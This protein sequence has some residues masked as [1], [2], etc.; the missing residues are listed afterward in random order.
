MTTGVLRLSPSG[1]PIENSDGGGLIP[2]EGIVMRAA[3]ENAAITSGFSISGTAAFELK[4]NM[5]DANAPFMRPQLT[6]ARLNV[7]YAAELNY[8]MAVADGWNTNVVTTVIQ[9]SIDDGANWITLATNS[10]N[11][12]GISANA[13]QNEVNMHIRTDPF[14]G[15]TVTGLTEGGSL[16]LR[17]TVMSGGADGQI[18]FRGTGDAPS[19]YLELKEQL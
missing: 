19:A 13:N 11:V 7:K 1:E 9:G 10:N 3:F 18:S 12:P 6:G 16:M 4:E 15:S 17:A 14:L 8:L 5:S 2:G